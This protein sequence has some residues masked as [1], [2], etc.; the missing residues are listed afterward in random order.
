MKFNQTKTGM[1]MYD[2]MLKDVEYFEKNKNKTYEIQMLTPIEYLH[3]CA[4]GFGVTIKDLSNS[5]SSKLKELK[6]IENEVEKWNM[7]MLDYAHGFSQEGITR[8]MLAYDKGI[9]EIPVMI[10][11][12]KNKNEKAWY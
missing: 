7:P 5:R 1:P 6:K 9:K 8:S 2:D 4:K 10:I 12:R 11:T 3:M